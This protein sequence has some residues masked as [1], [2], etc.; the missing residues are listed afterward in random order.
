VT[1]LGP[2]LASI[3]IDFPRSLFADEAFKR[4]A[5]VMMARATTAFEETA[6]GM[7]CILTPVSDSDDPIII[8]REFRREV[9]DQ[10]LRLL[11]EEKTEP[12]RT[13]ILGLAFSRTG[14]QG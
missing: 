4:A 11:V 6:D 9:L 5:L 14:L 2:R 7:R 10:D 8:E 3:A 1:E 12:V 13:A